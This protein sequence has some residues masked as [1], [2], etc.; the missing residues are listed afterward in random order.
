MAVSRPSFALHLVRLVR[1]RYHCGP[2]VHPTVANNTARVRVLYL[3]LR[4]QVDYRSKIQQVFEMERR[5]LGAIAAAARTFCFRDEVALSTDTTIDPKNNT[6]TD[7]ATTPAAATAAAAATTTL[8]LLLLP[9]TI[10]TRIP[11]RIAHT[12]I[13]T[14]LVP[15]LLRILPRTHP[16]PNTSGPEH[17][18][19]IRCSFPSSHESRWSACSGAAW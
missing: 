4:T 1:S 9:L 8:L 7:D 15:I 10:P 18:V 5:E 6:D 11:T 3:S 2:H 19:T 14:H 16:A 12:N 13:D 17:I